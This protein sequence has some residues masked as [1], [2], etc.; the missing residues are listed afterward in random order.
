MSALLLGAVGDHAPVRVR[1]RL[2]VGALPD[3]PH[4]EHVKGLGEVCPVNELLHALTADA[5]QHAPDLCGPGKF[6]HVKNHRHDASS[7]LT[8]GQDNGRL[9][10]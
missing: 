1:P 3:L 6:T 7:H 2:D 8:R 5:A 10:T 4:V 9:V